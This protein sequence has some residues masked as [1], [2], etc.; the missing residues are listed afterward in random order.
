MINSGNLLSSKTF[1]VW[2]EAFDWGTIA[3]NCQT[4][5][6]HWSSRTCRHSGWVSVPSCRAGPPIWFWFSKFLSA[7]DS[8]IFSAG[9]SLQQARIR[10]DGFSYILEILHCSGFQ[11]HCR[12]HQKEAILFHLSWVGGQN[13]FGLHPSAWDR[14]GCS[15]QRDWSQE[16]GQTR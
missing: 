6:G 9:P 15:S 8:M 5:Q 10:F 11:F 1:W 7:G 13:C 14:R 4:R 12:H 2:Y 3:S 16:F